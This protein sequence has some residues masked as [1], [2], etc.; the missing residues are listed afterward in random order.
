[1]TFQD[2]FLTAVFLGFGSL[3]C[4]MMYAWVVVNLH[5]M[6][7]ARMPTRSTPARRPELELAPAPLKRAA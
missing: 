7:Q 2:I 3:F 6:K 1:M 4:V 5:E